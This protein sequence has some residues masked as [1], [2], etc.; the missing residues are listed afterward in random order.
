MVKCEY[1]TL[2]W[3]ITFACVRALCNDEQDPLSINH[4]DLSKIA[5]DY[6]AQIT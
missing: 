5:T 6:A 1:L 2:L 4:K 3:F